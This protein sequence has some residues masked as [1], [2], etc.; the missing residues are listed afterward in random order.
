MAKNGAY[1]GVV[2]GAYFHAA[3][4]LFGLRQKSAFSI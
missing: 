3:F 1:F 2:F 4:N